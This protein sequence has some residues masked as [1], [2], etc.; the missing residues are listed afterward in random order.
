MEETLRKWSRVERG[1]KIPEDNESIDIHLQIW[2][3]NE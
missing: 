3:D 1:D 2:I